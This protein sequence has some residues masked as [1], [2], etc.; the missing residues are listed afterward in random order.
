VRKAAALLFAAAAASG[1]S[2]LPKKSVQ[3]AVAAAPNEPWTPPAAAAMPQAAPAPAPQIPEEYTKPGTTLSLGQLVDVALKNNPATREAWF[4]ARAA[5]AEVGSKRS[6]YFPYV[7]VDGILERQKQSAVGGQFTFLQTTYGPAIAA[8]WLLFNFGAREAEVEE[9]TRILYA[10]DWTHNA[11]IQ[12]VVLSVAQAYY[13]YLNAKA[14]VAAR[15]ANLAEA[16]SNLA[17]AE[18]RHRAG[19][20]TI[21]D[22]LLA[23]TSAS[24]SE[25]ALQIVQGQ[26]QVIRGALA[27]AIGVDATVAVDVGSLPEELPLDAVKKGVDELIAKA[28]VE[29]PDLAAQRFRALAAESRIRS[30]AVDGL[31]TLSLDASGNRTFYSRPGVPDPFSTNWAGAIS[32]RIPVFRGFDTAYQ[33]QKAREEAE[34]AKASAER[35]EDQVIL[36][37]WS[38]YYGVQTAAQT[39]LTTRDL[40]ASARQS[41]DVAEGRYRAG[42]G[43]ILDLLTAQTAYADAR[44]QEAQARSLWFLAMA[45]LAYATG[46]LQPGSPEIRA[47]PETKGSP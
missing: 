11:A 4:A 36:D 47:L 40:L 29:R 6:L 2:L 10:A 33:V 3:D 1:C 43:S 41:N 31:P 18:E 9:A 34:L 25:L 17:A 23:R 19:V 26:V 8:T 24:Q 13:Q 5:A 15:E 44:S 21:A 37:V 38:S 7:E 28:V 22:V 35:T 32:L 45:Q 46:V 42:V 39:V 27:T 16:R 20:A 14:Q 12:D 30:S